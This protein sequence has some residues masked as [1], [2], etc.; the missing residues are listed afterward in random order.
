MDF[1]LVG[2]SVRYRRVLKHLKICKYETVDIN[3]IDSI[4]S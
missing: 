4:G 3:I 1:D 2:L